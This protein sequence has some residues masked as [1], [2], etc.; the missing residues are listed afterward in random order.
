M[1]SAFFGTLLIATPAVAQSDSGSRDLCPDRPGLNTPTCTVD[2]GRVQVELSLADWTRDKAGPVRADDVL[3]GD[4][5]LRVGVSDAA[6]IRIGWSS[7]GHQTVHD[8]VAGTR[9]ADSGTGDLTLGVKYSL[10]SPDGSGTSVGILPSVTVPT[11]TGPLQSGDW[12]ASVQ[13]PVSFD[14]GAGV[15]FGLTPELAAAVDG[16]G[17]GRHAAFA[18]TGGF[19]FSPIDN[20]AVAIE[21]QVARDDDPAGASTASVAGIALGY[22]TSVNSQID[23]GSQFGL[24]ANAADV[25]LYVG[26]T[27]RF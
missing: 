13:V 19:G 1:R 26:V 15:S 8:R 21:A 10:M 6:E 18:L 17:D 7:Y 2:S 24:N 12:S 25:Q 20:L 27:R 11:G 4:V 9:L 22:Q 5:L 14:I 16:D 3:L 23:V